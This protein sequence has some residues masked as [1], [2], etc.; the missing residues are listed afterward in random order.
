M[1]RTLLGAATL[2]LLAASIGSICAPSAQSQQ[3]AS[4]EAGPVVRIS[5]GGETALPIQIKSRA[6]LPGR[7][8]VLIRGLP[9]EFTLSSG[10]MFDSGVWAVPPADIARLKIVAGPQ[11]INGQLPLTLSLVLL[12]GTV[13]ANTAIEVVVSEQP[14]DKLL[15]ASQGRRIAPETQATVGELQPASGKTPFTQSTRASIPAAAPAAPPPKPPA[16]KLP[17]LRIAAEEEE[18]RLKSGQDALDLDDIAGARLI[19]EYLANR[20]SAAGAYRLAQTYDPK[21]L[22]R[23]TIGSLYKPD[24]NVAKDWYLKAAEMG[25]VEARN[26]LAGGQ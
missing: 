6:P 7:A 25:Y 20:G 26:K 21:V 16:A 17:A 14:D 8:M 10:R 22:A 2:S 9:A 12:D 3:L 15:E 23:T 13:L 4:I 5:E 18:E 24:E 11:I 1:N 19:F